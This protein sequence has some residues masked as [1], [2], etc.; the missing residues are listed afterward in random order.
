MS[1]NDND[2]A[3]H[4]KCVKY[5][6]WISNKDD[7]QRFNFGSYK[8]ALTLIWNFLMDEKSFFDTTTQYTQT[9]KKNTTAHIQTWIRQ[10]K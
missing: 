3:E 6:Q 4:V 9:Q 5:N 8:N 10:I 2:D 1:H 7:C